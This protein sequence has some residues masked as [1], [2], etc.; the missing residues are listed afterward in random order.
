[1]ARSL[2]WV[3]FSLIVCGSAWARAAAEPPQTPGGCLVW[4]EP[5]PSN[6][7]GRASVVLDCSHSQPADK[8][9]LVEGTIRAERGLGK[10]AIR[11]EV[12]GS[13]DKAIFH[14]STDTTLDQ[15]EGP[16][17]F[18]WDS[19]SISPGSYKARFTLLRPPGI[20]VV[21]RDYIV[22]KAVPEELKKRIEAAKQTQDEVLGMLDKLEQ[23]GVKPPFMRI[24]A[25]IARDYLPVAQ[26]A[27]DGADW[28]RADE[29][30]SYVESVNEFARAELT[31]GKSVPGLW[32]ETPAP[33]PESIQ[34]HDGAFTSDGRPVFLVG[35]YLGNKPSPERIARLA[36]YGL[37]FA[38]FSYGPDQTL[39]TATLDA[40]IQSKLDPV[41]KAALENRVTLM[42]SLDPQSMPG[43]ALQQNPEM[44]LHFTDDSPETIADITHEAGRKLVNRHF[45]A[46]LP[47]LER[48]KGLAGIA[49]MEEPA[50]KFTGDEIRAR[51]LKEVKEHYATTHVLNKAWK[52]LFA[53]MDE[54]EIG[55]KPVNPRYQGSSAYRYEWQ[56]FHQRL[57][58]EYVSSLRELARGAGNKPLTIAFADDLFAPGEAERGVDREMLEP[59]LDATSVCAA[60]AQK[61]P[62]YSVEYPK[63][64]PIYALMKSLAPGKPLINFE[65]TLT[66]NVLSDGAT[67]HR[68]FYT[69]LWEAAIAG[70]NAF[71]LNAELANL[72]PDAFEGYAAACIDLNRLAPIVTAFQNAPAE[73]AIFWS[74]PSKIYN[75]GA[76][77]LQAALDAYEGCSFSGYKARFISEKQCVETKLDGVRVFVVP[78]SPAVRNEVFDI[79]KGYMAGDGAV[80]RTSFSIL[81]DEYGHSRRDIISNTHHTVLVRGQNL[82]TE[83]LHAMD[84]VSTFEVLP[85]IPRMI[86]PSGY[87][88][89]GVKSQYVVFDGKEYLYAVNL[90]KDRITV[91]L[92]GGARTG[93]DLIAGGA[94][95]FPCSLE[96]LTPMLIQLEKKN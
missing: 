90:R 64:L 24:R 43:W 56:M 51:F 45:A 47:Y 94:V 35:A 91:D 23:E 44:T 27:I 79:L 70:V 76:P 62:Y 22:R 69:Q 29:T 49:L 14:S 68:F 53:K 96:P 40:D 78:D 88:L 34:I 32:D 25:E 85:G 8:S 54:V 74:M 42:A 52:G 67:S 36:R 80:V 33:S 26:A 89:E 86:N 2:K 50:F 83:Y 17:H 60:S 28:P 66:Q 75:N 9:V 65:G 7:D 13:D 59:Q 46:L 77:H 30:L 93:R 3:V 81:Y 63:A 58:D 61:S 21:S 4:F 41:F 16:F 20:L 92:S 1:M 11:F 5:G 71:A 15:V 82:P 37:N 39:A 31:F 84:A 10:V 19:S 12:L 18:Q 95:S 38:A 73:V 57:G 55:T 87:P 6:G 72:S 48:Q